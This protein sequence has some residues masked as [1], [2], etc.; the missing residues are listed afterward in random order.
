MANSRPK[1]PDDATNDTPDVSSVCAVT[2]VTVAGKAL[3][4]LILRNPEEIIRWRAEL[5]R[6]LRE[7]AAEAKLFGTILFRTFR[8][9]LRIRFGDHPHVR[10]MTDFLRLPRFRERFPVKPPFLEAEALMRSALG[11]RG[12]IDGISAKVVTEIRLQLL[13]YLAEDMGMSA[14]QVD[15]L[16]VS[17]ENTVL[18]P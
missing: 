16:L 4:G 2:P 18:R 5:N 6:D 14:D 7:G 10:T 9:L 15:E 1:G 12:L 3:R 17:V 8:Q 11:E 13:M